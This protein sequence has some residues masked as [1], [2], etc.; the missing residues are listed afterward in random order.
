MTVP[1]GQLASDDLREPN[2]ELVPYVVRPHGR[3]GEL[4]RAMW[5]RTEV[6]R[7]AAVRGNAA[8]AASPAGLSAR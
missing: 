1:K 7:C 5:Q 6:F 3:V 8:V 4:S 2:V